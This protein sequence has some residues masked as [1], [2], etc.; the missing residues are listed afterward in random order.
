L[1]ILDPHGRLLLFRYH[2][3]HELPFWSTAGGELVDGED[4]RAAAA[5]ELNEE[6]GFR[7][8]IGPLLKEREE[9]F[10]VARSTPAR[11][12]EQYFL[13]K[14]ERADAPN[15]AGW[16]DEERSTI[17]DWKWWS[18]AE[19]RGAPEPFRPEWLG[20]LL[21]STLGRRGKALGW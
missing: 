8:A 9:V 19:M 2:D 17:Q 10:A 21:E 1:I 12:A 6:T 18:L 13:V 3:E 4:Y 14:C 7:C 20:D 11:W 15:R 16:T 5:R